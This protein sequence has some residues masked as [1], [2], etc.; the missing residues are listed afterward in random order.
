MIG[1]GLPRH[2][3]VEFLRFLR[4]VNRE[5]PKGLHVPMILASYATHKHDQ[6]QLWL[7]QHPGLHLHVIPT[8]SSWLNVVERWFRAL[9]EKATRAAFS[10]RSPT[11]SLPS[12]PT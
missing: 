7:S 6:V 4:R 9:D 3:R 12:K 2:R 11:S 5:L 8:S 1:E 10:P